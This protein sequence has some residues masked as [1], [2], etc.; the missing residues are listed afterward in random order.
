M[1]KGFTFYLLSEWEDVY[2]FICVSNLEIKKKCELQKGQRYRQDIT[3]PFFVVRLHCNYPRGESPEHLHSHWPPGWKKN[4]PQS[5]GFELCGLTSAYTVTW[6]TG[7]GRQ[8]AFHS[9]VALNLSRFLCQIC[10]SFARQ[11]DKHRPTKANSL[12]TIPAPCH[13]WSTK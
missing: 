5:L 4:R 3:P 7:G 9:Q 10:R 2:L 6:L 11:L 13:F 1:V 8:L 12:I